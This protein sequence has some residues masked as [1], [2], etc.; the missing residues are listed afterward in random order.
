[1]SLPEQKN[2]LLTNESVDLITIYK[3]KH[4]HK[5]NSSYPVFCQVFVF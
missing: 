5:H 2:S 4:Y 3:K 1:M